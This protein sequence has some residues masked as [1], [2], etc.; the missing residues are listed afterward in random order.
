MTRLSNATLGMTIAFLTAACGETTPGGS[1]SSGSA[2]GSGGGSAAQ[3][4]S[5]AGGMGG[6]AQSA[7]SSSATVGGG[8]NGGGGGAAFVCDPAA[9]PGSIYERTGEVYGAEA[10]VSM[11]KYRGEVMLIVNTA[12]LCGFTPQYAPL[13]ILENTFKGQGLHVLGFLSNDFGNQ[14]GTDGQVDA[15]K[16]QY[17]VTFDQF[18]I[19][20]VTSPTAE[21]V[22][23]WLESQPNPSPAIPIEPTWNFHKY[24]ISRDGQLVGHW[25]SEVY[26]GADPNDATSTFDTNE[27]VMAIKAELAK[28]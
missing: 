28:P 22:F 17:K 7:S 6:A 11:C 1:G 4:G 5:G 25:A 10:P 19:D 13:E 8:G 2:T 21:P 16:D 26:P 15:C 3:T 20:H 9:V 12:A 24:L 23:A 18:A 27:I 14:G